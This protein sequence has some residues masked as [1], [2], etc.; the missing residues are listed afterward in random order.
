MPITHPTLP[1]APAPTRIF[2][3]PFNSSSTGHQRAGNVLAGSTAWRD[4]RAYKLAS[5]FQDSSGRGGNQHLLDLVGAGSKDFGKDG[6]EGNGARERGEPGLREGS[7][8]DI[9]GSMG[10]SRKRVFDECGSEIAGNRV[11][12]EDTVAVETQQHMDTKRAASHSQRQE[13]E[14]TATTASVPNISPKLPSTQPRPIFSGLTIYLNGS[15]APLISDHKLKTV[16]VA[17]GGAVCLGLARRSVTHVILGETGLAAGKIQ[18]EVRK[19]GGE[20]V[21]YVTAQWVLDCVGAGRR[22]AEGP[23]MPAGLGVGGSRQRSVEVM[24]AKGKD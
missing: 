20:S 11:K 18:T 16:F 21:K 14:I 1:K 13:G 8:Q 5:Q 22:K 6:R 23:Y 15:T 10:K 19:I 9:R 17:H 24:F 3:D 4:S 2:F 12:V 7:W